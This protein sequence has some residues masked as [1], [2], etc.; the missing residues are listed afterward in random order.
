MLNIQ[1]E[2]AKLHQE[3]AALVKDDD[4]AALYLRAMA[5]AEKDPSTG[6]NT[7]WGW[8]RLFQVASK[9]PNFRDVFHE[10]RYNIALCRFNMSRVQKSKSEEQEQLKKA[11]DAI[12][13][14]ATAVRL[15]PGMGRLAAAI[16]CVDERN[17]KGVGREALG[18]APESAAGTAAAGD[19]AKEAAVK[20]AASPAPPPLK[21]PVGPAIS[22]QESGVS[23][24]PRGGD[25]RGPC[26]EPETFEL[27]QE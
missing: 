4:K 6:K 5:G 11:K 14:N 19:A 21:L 2:A 20:P 1:V 17:P 10:A 27:C 15:R 8:G 7:I 24:S 3:W 9:Y 12:T 18:I 16:R 25:A 13:S 26:S 22:G 23:P